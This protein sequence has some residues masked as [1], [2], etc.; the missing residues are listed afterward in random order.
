[1]KTIGKGSGSSLH[2]SLQ[3]E[4]SYR[5]DEAQ[6]CVLTLS[7]CQLRLVLQHQRKQEPSQCLVQT[8]LTLATSGLRRVKP[9]KDPSYPE[10]PLLSRHGLPR[11][12]CY[13]LCMQAL[14]GQLGE[15][16]S[17]HQEPD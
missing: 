12:L 15:E 4:K 1:M 3:D 10:K 8:T 2:Y 11:P 16:G 13:S 17:R 9:E 7:R 5:M 14:R 6:R